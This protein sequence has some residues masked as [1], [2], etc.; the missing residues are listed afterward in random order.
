MREQVSLQGHSGV[1]PKGP[2]L[3]P[4]RP[5]LGQ[6]FNVPLSPFLSSSP[7]P[8]H[9][10]PSSPCYTHQGKHTVRAA[11]CGD[12]GGGGLAVNR[13]ATSLTAS[14]PPTPSDPPANPPP[15]TPSHTHT[16]AVQPCTRTHVHTFMPYTLTVPWTN[17]RHSVYTSST[18]KS[19]PRAVSVFSR[20]STYGGQA[21][22]PFSRQARQLTPSTATTTLHIHL[23]LYC[24]Y[25]FSEGFLLFQRA[26]TLLHVE[27]VA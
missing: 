9:P 12:G 8:S 5:C 7:F 15:T 6:T 10:L 1:S 13:L 24:S 20:R 18:Q 19:V 2:P 21:R 27:T 22:Q 14:H 25:K 17:L 16:L 3:T 11:R 4:N 23:A 26:R